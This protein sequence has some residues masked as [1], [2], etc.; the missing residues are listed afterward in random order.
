MDNFFKE[1]KDY[2]RYIIDYLADN[3]GYIER[4]FNEGKYNPL[5]AMD[6][7]LLMQF[8]ETTQKDTVDYI[9]S[10]YSNADELI[11]K[12]INNEITKRDS[13]LIS[14]LKN[15]V[16]FDNTTH[17]DLM[18]DKPATSFNEDLIEKYNSNIFSVM[19][20]VNH[21]E[22]ERI[23]LVIFLNGIAIIT[24]ELKSNQSGQSYKDAIWQYQNERDYNTRLLS[25]KNGALVN[26]AM[27]TKEAYMCTELKGKTSFF[28][29]FNKG[30]EDGGKG[31]PHN[32]NGLNVSYMWEDILTKDTLLYL[33][34][35][36]IFI[37][38]E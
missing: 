38:K 17:L 15:G 34:K 31:N 30:T 32:D 16:Y 19:E 21:K 13:S 25:F 29:P 3:N 24:I 33:I 5:Y 36:F 12:K 4:K 6:T 7:E 35:N 8:L 14:K 10:I 1:R 22:D 2:Q 9:R 27:D 11:I 23:D 26:F 20:E 37:E 28:L 18:Y